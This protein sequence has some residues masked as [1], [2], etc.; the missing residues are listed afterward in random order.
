M[1]RA[2]GSSNTTGPIGVTHLIKVALPG[3]IMAALT[4]GP[5]VPEHISLLHNPKSTGDFLLVHL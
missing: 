2:V 1:G 4:P 5:V 3:L